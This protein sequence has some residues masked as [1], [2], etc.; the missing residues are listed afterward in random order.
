V[1][2]RKLTEE[3]GV[4]IGWSWSKTTHSASRVIAGGQGEAE[5]RDFRLLTE[6]EREANFG[7]SSMVEVFRDARD[8]ELGNYPLLLKRAQETLTEAGPKAGIQAVLAETATFRYGRT[9]KVGDTIK[10]VVGPG[11]EIEDILR[12]ATL[13]DDSSGVNAVPVVGDPQATDS[14][15]KLVAKS[16]NRLAAGLRSLRSER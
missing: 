3:S 7:R 12:T 4:L 13:T 15:D 5:D 1:R 9:A 8:V 2:N 10:A 14:H 16:I 6:L 11:V